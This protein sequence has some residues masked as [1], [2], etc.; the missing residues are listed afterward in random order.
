MQN[1]IATLLEAQIES[2]AREFTN[3]AKTVFYDDKQKRLIHAGEFGMLREACVRGLLKNFLPGIYGVAQGYVIGQNDEVSHQCDLIIYHKNFT[4][5]FHTP[6][7]QRFFPVES[8]IAVGEIKSKI[9][10]A[11]LDDALS[12][13]AKVKMMRE[14]VTDA[15]IAR[16]R[17]H[18][19]RIYSPKINLRDQ[20]ITFL[21]GEEFVCSNNIVS[22]RIKKP[23]GASLPRHRVNLVA[24]IKSGTCTYKDENS[25]P[26]MYPVEPSGVEL[27]VRLI[28][29]EPGMYGHLA[30]FLR[31]LIMLVEDCTVLY[32]E[33]TRHL[34]SLLV[35]SSTDLP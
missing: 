24:T 1:I 12:K 20:I 21:I 23:W 34:D 8:V 27:P 29:S 19:N 13:L 28:T 15:V 30:L 35:C 14:S 26:W 6:E 33:L 5:Y 32:P 10:G 9:D 11:V 7:E 2:F 22:E 3:T 31:Y 17:P 18:E 4:P 16:C 25:R